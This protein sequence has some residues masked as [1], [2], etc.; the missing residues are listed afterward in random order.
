MLVYG[1]VKDVGVA[2]DRVAGHEQG[3]NEAGRQALVLVGFDAFGHGVPDAELLGVCVAF[4]AELF[5]QVVKF[6]G[7]LVGVSAWMVVVRA[8]M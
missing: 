4:E 7:A 5:Q 6:G 2:V 3:G 1:L 8:L